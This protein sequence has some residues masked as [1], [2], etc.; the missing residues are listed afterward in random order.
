[1]KIILIIAPMV[2][3]Y[4]YLCNYA[5]MYFFWESGYIGWMLLYIG[6]IGILQ[7]RIKMKKMIRKETVMEKIIIGIIVFV[8]L[9]KTVLLTVTPFTD[10]Y[11]ASKKYLLANGTIQAEVGNIHGFSVV[12]EG[13]IHQST[14][15]DKVNGLATIVLL[16][17]G[18][19]KYKRVTIYVAKNENEQEWVVG[20]ME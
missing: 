12:P 14:Q 15:A 5:G 7:Q 19:K 2:I 18:D 20:G 3:I 6:F 11:A 10:A 13:S 8:L 9:L 17:K 16:I 4:G 1:M